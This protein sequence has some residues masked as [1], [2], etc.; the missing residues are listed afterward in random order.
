MTAKTVPKNTTPVQYQAVGKALIAYQPRN[1][2]LTA[3]DTATISTALRVAFFDEPLNMRP[4][5]RQSGKVSKTVNSS[6]ALFRSRRD[7]W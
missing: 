3:S 4:E 1:V 5:T 7:V 2:R 6:V